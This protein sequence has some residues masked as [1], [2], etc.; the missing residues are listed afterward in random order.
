MTIA[1]ENIKLLEGIS[2]KREKFTFTWEEYHSD[3]GNR[4]ILYAFYKLI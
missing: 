4:G 2:T 1:A 3:W